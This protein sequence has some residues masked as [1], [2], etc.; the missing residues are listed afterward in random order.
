MILLDT[1]HLSVLA[2]ATSTPARRLLERLEQC[3]DEFV[4]TTIV[5]VEE[6][7]KGWLAAIHRAG[8]PQDQI[9]PYRQLLTFIDF[10][11]EWDITLFDVVAADCFAELRRRRIRIGT[12]DLKIAA[13]AL[14]RNALV[15]TANRRD[16]DLI[17]GL[18]V[19]NW[20]Q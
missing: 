3:D 5:S 20:L 18:R 19:E 10:I 7:F 8:Q 1:N 11:A 17:P 14:T 9:S 4:G 6:C 13:I 2:F 15:L 16:F 12:Q